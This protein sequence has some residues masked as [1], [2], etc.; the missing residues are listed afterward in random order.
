MFKGSHLHIPTTYCTHTYAAHMCAFELYERASSRNTTKCERF[1]LFDFS[2]KLLQNKIR[3]QT[4]THQNW[5]C[6]HVTFYYNKIWSRN[7]VIIIFGGLPLKMY[8][9]HTAPRTALTITV[10]TDKIIK[11]HNERRNVAWRYRAEDAA[12]T[13]VKYGLSLDWW[14]NIIKACFNARYVYSWPLFSWF[15]AFRIWLWR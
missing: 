12:Q 9:P 3:I 4:E 15:L 14:K 7:K 6:C 8:T 11:E 10:Y 1:I 13:R 2:F 5:T